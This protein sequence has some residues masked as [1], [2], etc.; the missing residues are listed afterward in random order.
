[1]QAAI[2]ANKEKLRS[3]QFIGRCLAS[4][5]PYTPNSSSVREGKLKNNFTK[6]RTI[7]KIY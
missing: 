2:V 1:M 6:Q 7:P 5:G 3:G 4:I